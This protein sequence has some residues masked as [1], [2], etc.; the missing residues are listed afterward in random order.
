MPAIW[1]HVSGFD[2][3]FVPFR[4]NLAPNPSRRLLWLGFGG[5][6]RL[7]RAERRSLQYV[8]PVLAGPSWERRDESPQALNHATSKAPDS[9]EEA[10]PALIP[11]LVGI[12]CQGNGLCGSVEYR[13]NC[14]WH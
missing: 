2:G 5:G 9:F 8:I 7:R 12:Q 1:G 11:G 13:Q 4:A 3:G 14:V 6:D 10:E